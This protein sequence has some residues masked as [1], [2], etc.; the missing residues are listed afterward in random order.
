MA[1]FTNEPKETLA[2]SP[3]FVLALAIERAVNALLDYQYLVSVE[4]LNEL[5]KEA[6][7]NVRNAWTL[8]NSEA[9]AE[10][11][12][13]QCDLHSVAWSRK[14]MRAK[15]AVMARFPDLCSAINW[16]NE[17]ASELSYRDK[18]WMIWEEDR[19]VVPADIDSSADYVYDLVGFEDSTD[20][21]SVY[22]LR[23]LYGR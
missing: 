9:Q 13:W 5:C 1:N 11:P 20:I 3:Y 23:H 4:V 14:R 2:T 15:R 21:A 22:K 16:V 19:S 7:V 12:V 17:Q 18:V 10:I 8:I 6:S